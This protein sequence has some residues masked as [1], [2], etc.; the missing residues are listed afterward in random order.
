[1]KR[2]YKFFSICIIINIILFFKNVDYEFELYN[3]VT[4]NIQIY[5]IFYFLI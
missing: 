3:L 2:N 4:S 1:M 5:L